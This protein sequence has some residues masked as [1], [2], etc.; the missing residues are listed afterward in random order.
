MFGGVRNLPPG[1]KSLLK[2]HL[3][4]TWSGD[5]LSRDPFGCA[6]KGGKGSVGFISG[7]VILP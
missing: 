6:G 5:S 1:W 4:L 7:S 2:I 3:S